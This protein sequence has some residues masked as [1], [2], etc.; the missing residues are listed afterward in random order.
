MACNQDVDKPHC[1][2][3]WWPKY[4][5]LGMSAGCI[6][7]WPTRMYTTKS[8]IVGVYNSLPRVV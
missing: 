5:D 6:V 4:K 1:V 7:F 2:V 3:R 8:E